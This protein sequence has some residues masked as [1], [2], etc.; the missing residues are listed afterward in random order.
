MA[1]EFV[2]GLQGDHPKY[3]KAAAGAMCCGQ[4]MANIDFILSKQANTRWIRPV[5]ESMWMN[6]ITRFRKLVLLW[7]Y[8][9]R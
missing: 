3:L 5:S 2:K 8:L 4:A 9:S 7:I 1:A 6:S